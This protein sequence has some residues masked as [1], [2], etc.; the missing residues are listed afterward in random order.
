MELHEYLNP[1]DNQY[2]EGFV[3]KGTRYYFYTNKG[4]MVFNEF[5]YYILIIWGV[6]M[7]AKLQLWWLPILF[8]ICLPILVIVGYFSVHHM[9]KI[10]DYLTTKY[11]THFG[12]WGYQLQVERVELLKEIRD[13][14]RRLNGKES[15]KDNQEQV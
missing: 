11:G 6:V 10:M 9:Q 14:L 8:F 15:N 12:K 1:K 4:L 13:E 7:A 5:R 3:N 2:R